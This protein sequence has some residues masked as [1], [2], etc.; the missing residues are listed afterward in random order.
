MDAITKISGSIIQHGKHNNRIYLMKLDSRDSPGI[1]A[2]LDTLA[3][4]NDYTKIF[5]KISACDAEP[6]FN[7]RYT[8]E[9]RIPGSHRGDELLFLAKYFDD[10]RKKTP[11]DQL[12][13]IKPAID[14]DGKALGALSLD[15]RFQLQKPTADNAAMMAK[16]YEKVFASYPFPIHEPE[17]LL[18]TMSQNTVYFGIW[19]QTRLVAL[20]SAEMDMDA[21]LVEMTDFAVLPEYRGNGLALFL[22]RQM[23]D[24]MRIKGITT[25][26]TI[27][28]SKSPGMNLTFSKAGYEYTG[29]L[30]NN[31]NICGNLESMNVWYK[32]I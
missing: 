9:A 6:F 28:R 29:T 2:T 3:T 5:A 24:E 14:K 25:A 8:V 19:E 4:Q 27:A 17:Y 11:D 26:Y 31:T 15:G 22:L 16:L 10:D 32:K 30:I 23:E 21:G 18:E 13:K 1:I 12:Q 7:S 20:S